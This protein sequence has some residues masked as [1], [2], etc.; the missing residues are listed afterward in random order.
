[1]KILVEDDVFCQDV[2]VKLGMAFREL[3][4]HLKQKKS[5][6]NCQKIL[7]K[8][9]EDNRHRLKPKVLELL[10]NLMSRDPSFLKDLDLR[11]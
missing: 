11:V 2:L 9:E 4:N 10:A 6:N 1:M 8:V 3:Q 5:L 7:Q